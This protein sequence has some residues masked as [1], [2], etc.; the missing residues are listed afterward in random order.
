MWTTQDLN[1]KLFYV[2]K[3]TIDSKRKV[4][5]IFIQSHDFIPLCMNL[6]VIIQIELPKTWIMRFVLLKEKYHLYFT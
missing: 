4:M 3:G 1:Y 5:L 2:E 6:H